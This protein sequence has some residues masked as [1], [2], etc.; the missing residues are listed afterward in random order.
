MLTLWYLS[1]GSLS[2]LMK[3]LVS[4][5]LSYVTD[6]NCALQMDP[7]YFPMRKLLVLGHR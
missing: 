5:Q 1:K 4:Q 7:K 3:F 2:H 6:L